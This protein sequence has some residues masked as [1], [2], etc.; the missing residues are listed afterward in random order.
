MSVRYDEKAPDSTER[1]RTCIQS[2]TRGAFTAIV[3]APTVTPC[4]GPL[5]DQGVA[6]PVAFVA[7]HQI[8]RKV[9]AALLGLG[10]VLANEA[11]EFLVE[12]VRFGR[13]LFVFVAGHLSLS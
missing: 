13:E 2:F 12:D 7:I 3:P 8:L 10:V 6:I 5:D 11:L 1:R 4:L 9:G